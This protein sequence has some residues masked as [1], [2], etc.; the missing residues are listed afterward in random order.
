MVKCPPKIY[1][2]SKGEVEGK[3]Y[4]VKGERYMAALKTR[5]WLSWDL[6]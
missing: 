3:R 2:E 1:L 5:P 6:K 4:N